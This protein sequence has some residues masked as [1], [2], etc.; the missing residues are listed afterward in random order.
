MDVVL[1]LESDHDHL[2]GSKQELVGAAEEVTPKLA[3]RD[4]DDSNISI[5]NKKERHL[6]NKENSHRPASEEALVVVACCV[7]NCS[8]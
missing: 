4:L 1:F 3:K 8:F 7:C 5:Q 2:S 6:V